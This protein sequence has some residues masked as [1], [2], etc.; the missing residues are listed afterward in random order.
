MKWTNKGHQFDEVA[1][2][3]LKEDISYYIWGAGMLGEVFY[4]GFH[5]EI[6]IL[7]FID[8]DPQKQNT[9]TLKNLPIFPPSILENCDKTSIK[10]LIASVWSAQIFNSLNDFGFTKRIDCFHTEEFSLVYAMYRHGKIQIN[11]LNHYITEKCTL[12][13]K[14]CTSHTAYLE[15]P[16]DREYQM[17]LKELD[18]FF[19]WVDKINML[20]IIGGDA[21]C[22]KNFD[23][24]IEYIGEKYYQKEVNRIEVYT[25]AVIIPTRSQLELFQKY[26]VKIRFTDYGE[27]TKSKQKIS[28]IISLLEDNDIEH[29]LMTLDYWMETCHPRENNGIPE[30]NLPA[31]F[32]SC[33]LKSCAGLYNDKIYY[34]NYPHRA[35]RIDYCEELPSDSFALDHFDAARK[36]ELVEYLLGYNEN[37]YLNACAKCYGNI[38]VNNKRIPVGEQVPRLNGV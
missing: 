13:C 18:H 2:E 23:D 33:D 32:E 12:N 37:G 30:A 28:E 27:F 35:S 14:Y 6:N 25:N 8:M 16:R 7:G 15:R 20:G 21:M 36:K 29:H 11:N 26:N 1:K 24:I 22:H 10:V 5:R 19:Q 34:C 17:V 31:F 38:N 4:D 9:K 3:I